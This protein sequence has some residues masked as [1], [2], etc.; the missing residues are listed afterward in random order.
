[1]NESPEPKRLQP[2]LMTQGKFFTLLIALLV[3]ASWNIVR[4][5][6]ANGS[7]SALTIGASIGAFVACSGIVAIVGWYANKLEK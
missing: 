1:M 7:A 3:G 5:Y 4:D 6:R 2:K